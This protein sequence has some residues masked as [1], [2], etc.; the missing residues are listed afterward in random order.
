[1]NQTYL[2]SSDIL[3][4]NAENMTKHDSILPKNIPFLFVIE[5]IN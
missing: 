2:L 4:V 5:S 3:K 1:M